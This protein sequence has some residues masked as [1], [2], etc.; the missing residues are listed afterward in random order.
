[1]NAQ[2][3]LHDLITRGVILSANGDRLDID[4]PDSVLTNE[5]LTTLSEHKAEL[6]A[7]LRTKPTERQR[8][9]SFAQPMV[10]RGR[11]VPT[12]CFWS[13]CD[14]FLTAYRKNLYFC[15]TCETW[16]EL[17]EPEGVYFSDVDQQ[18]TAES[19]WVN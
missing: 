18:I 19:E 11:W 1:M 9:G 13:S 5:L 12:G 7:L 14:G 2:V 4:A 16:F 8:T 3:L 17:R 15:P 10:V 6:L